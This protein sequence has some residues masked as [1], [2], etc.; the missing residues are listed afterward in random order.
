MNQREQK[1]IASFVASNSFEVFKK[2]LQERI[3]IIR[4]QKSKRDTEFETIYQLGNS[5]G[6]EEELIELPRRLED[7][8]KRYAG[9]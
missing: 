5:D 9:D 7:L 8:Y 1:I 3:A 4:R 2:F 6:R